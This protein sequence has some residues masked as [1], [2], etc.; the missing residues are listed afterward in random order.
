[1]AGDSRDMASFHD[2]DPT[3]MLER[4]RSGLSG[5]AEP[6]RQAGRR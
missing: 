5:E 3:E 6:R 1:M 2:Q 4:L